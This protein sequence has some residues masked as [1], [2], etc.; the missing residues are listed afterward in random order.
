MKVER[1]AVQPARR[2]L[3]LKHGLGPGAVVVLLWTCTPGATIAATDSDPA[4]PADPASA[5]TPTPEYVDRL[6]EG[7]AAT[8]DLADDG[9]A[10][11]DRSGM[12]RALR[13]ESRLQ[14][15]SNEQGRQSSAW[16]NLRGAVDTANYGSLSLDASAR[17]WEHSSQVRRG[18]GASFSLYQ[19]AMPFSGGWDASQ[20]LGVIQTL[21]PRLAG[22][23]GS[24]F[25]PTRLVEGASTQWRNESN[26]VTVQLSGGETGSFSSIGQGSFYGSGN[27]VAALG[28]EL[29]WTAG[30]DSLLPRGWGYSAVLSNAS[31]SAGQVVPGFGGRIGEAASQ[32]ISQ[33][34]RWED[35]GA[36][37]QAHWVASRN[38]DLAALAQGV[39]AG[40]RE[41]HSG[42]WLDA[43]VPAGDVTHRGGLHRLEPNLSWQ[44]SALGGNSQG[45]YYRWSR[46]GLR[47]QIEAQLSSTEPVDTATGG[48]SLRQVG[49]AV[50]H[51]IDQRLGIGGVVQL[52]QGSGTDWQASG[53]SELHQAWADVRLQAG[54]ETNSGRIVARRVSSDQTWQLPIGQRLSTSQAL[55]ST[56]EGALTPGSAGAGDFGTSL[57]L[58]IA[59][60]AD[61]GERIAL[62]VNARASLPL[63]SQ[64][65]RV[66]NVSATGQWRFAPGWSVGGLLGWSR[67][68]GLT[69]QATATPIPVLPGIITATVVPGTQSRDLWL[70]LRYEFQAGT[71]SVPIGRGARVGAGGGRIE[72]V[73]YLDDNGNGR[74]DALEARSANV[75]VTLDGRYTTRTDAQGR[76]EF[77]FVAP[78]AHT[79]S[80]SADTLPLPWLMPSTEPLRIDVAPRETTRLEIGA[81]RDRIAPNG[82]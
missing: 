27:H 60:G 1:P 62:D 57:E 37:A 16:V 23:Q 31:G 54:F 49:V 19:A 30:A 47:T 4:A 79:V 51:H 29:L 5:A 63:S 78:G 80:V 38:E 61:V 2:P 8:P 34:L 24:F 15:S 22:Q 33:S 52:S 71:A 73:V 11:F 65:A 40:N 69:S 13:V 41:M 75:S 39:T 9:A 72:G 44:G 26:G 25:V 7:L 76:F 32:G 67:A 17:L 66:Y 46:Q 64:A 20:G 45:G 28:V 12:P 21:S 43:S 50:R 58:A 74:F 81:T 59:G 3:G 36:S 6:I 82:E 55:N 18:A 35:D 42:V 53:Y 14:S 70:T 10:E 68:S 77:P 56:R 48:A